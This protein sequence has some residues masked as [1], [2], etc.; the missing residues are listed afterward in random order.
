VAG[1]VEYSSD[2]N[3]LMNQR[4][5]NGCW[6]SL[7]LFNGTLSDTAKIL[8]TKFVSDTTPQYFRLRS[9]ITIGTARFTLYSLLY[10]DN[11]GQIRPILRTFGTE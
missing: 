4:M 10:R 2:P 9:F 6:P 11:S 8:S 3:A 1:K 7:S 5:Q